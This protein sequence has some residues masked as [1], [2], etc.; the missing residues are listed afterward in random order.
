VYEK[1]NYR[2]LPVDA[3]LE[4][5]EQVDRQTDFAAIFVDENVSGYSAQDHENRVALFE[6]MI[7]K[8]FRFVWGA[9]S[10]I[11]VYKKPELLKLMRAAGCRALFIGLESID[12]DLG[13][14]VNKSFADRIDYKEAIK[15]IHRHRIGVIGSFMLGLDNQDMSYAK[16]LPR[17]V[18]KLNIEY[19]RLFFLTAW[20]GT[21]LYKRLQEQGRIA[22]GYAQVRKDIPN[23]V[24]SHFSEEEIR[25]ARQWIKKEFFTKPYIAKLILRW[26]VK[27]PGMLKFFIGVLKSN[28]GGDARRRKEEQWEKEAFLKDLIEEHF[29]GTGKEFDEAQMFGK[30][31][32]IALCLASNSMPQGTSS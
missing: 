10:T 11:D 28:I 4:D 26:L 2:T 31:G 30:E 6:G 5:M 25:E 18:K 23:I 15:V 27:D 17:A 32:G 1:K 24:Y 7:K 3:I 9:Q 21:A 19:P 16:R 12:S 13:D 22:A 20:P 14:Q 8:K 29:R